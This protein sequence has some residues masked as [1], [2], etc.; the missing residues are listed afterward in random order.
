MTKIDQFQAGYHRT[1][2]ALA[3][4]SWPDVEARRMLRI[5]DSQA[6]P[7]NRYGDGVRK[8]CR[9]VLELYD[10]EGGV[11]CDSMRR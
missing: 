11:A 10:T 4:H 1:K 7:G 2:E 5:L 6:G 8:A 9:E 3:R